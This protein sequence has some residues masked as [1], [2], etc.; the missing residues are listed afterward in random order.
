MGDAIGSTPHAS[1]AQH[2]GW[3]ARG[4]VSGGGTPAE[5]EVQQYYAQQMQ[6]AARAPC[7]P[8]EQQEREL[9]EQ[10]ATELTVC[11]ESAPEQPIGFVEVCA[12]V[13]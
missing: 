9:A 13:I 7:A 5:W 8:S 10:D 6:Q 3:G 2:I 12:T 1:T 11:M 4:G